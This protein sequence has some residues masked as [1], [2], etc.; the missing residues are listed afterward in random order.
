M[1]V[2]AEQR[3]DW[4]FLIKNL[5]MTFI[6]ASFHWLSKKVLKEKQYVWK[7]TASGY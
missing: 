1:E 6:G 2:E 3:D 7:Q 5:F 4:E